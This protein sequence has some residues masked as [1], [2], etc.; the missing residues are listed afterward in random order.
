[1]L[2]LKIVGGA[3]AL[4]AWCWGL[5][6]AAGWISAPDTALALSGY[7]LAVSLLVLPLGLVRRTRFDRKLWFV[8]VAMLMVGCTRIDPGHVGIKVDNFGSQRGVQDFTLRTGWVVYLPGA[9]SVFEWPT[10]T[11]TAVW[12]ASKAEGKPQDESI[13]FNSKEGLVFNAD[14]SLAYHLE[15]QRVPH[16][17]VK[18]RTDA[19]DTFTHGYLR[20]AAR[21]AFNDIAVE[22]SAE[23]IYG[24]KKETVVRRVRERLNKENTEY[25]VALDQFGFIG[26]PRPPQGIVDAINAK[27]RATQD[28]IRVENELRQARAQAAKAVAE[29]EGNA[30]AL[31]KRAEGEAKANQ[32]LAASVT[33]PLLEWQRLQITREA[34]GRWDGRRPMVEGGAG[35]GLL[36]N[37]N[38]ASH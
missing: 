23:E 38:P 10:Y 5:T 11:Q 22:Y 12:T 3:V 7:V 4:L 2:G 6:V 36:L 37:I 14:I 17:Y 35:S 28:A 8:A 29:A 13:S 9:S 27:I 33:S 19:M 1:M 32:T 18:F 26:A 20:N 31:V 15:S 30:A 21:E 16:F 34:I 25:G 24:E